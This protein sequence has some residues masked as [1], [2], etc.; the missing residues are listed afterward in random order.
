[1]REIAIQESQERNI[2][3]QILEWVIQKKNSDTVIFI[4]RIVYERSYREIV[5]QDRYWIKWFENLSGS[6]QNVVFI[7]SD[8]IRHL[9]RKREKTP[10]T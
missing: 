2:I 4:H 9:P 10:N 5:I 8:A 7:V 3:L 1:M 6:H